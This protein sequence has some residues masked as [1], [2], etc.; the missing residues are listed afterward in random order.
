MGQ[1]GQ[2]SET[3]QRPHYDEKRETVP[4]SI[5]FFRK[6]KEWWMEEVGVKTSIYIT[7]KAAIIIAKFIQEQTGM[8]GSWITYTRIQN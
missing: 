7:I 5:F 4:I 1:E 3:T 2:L 8:C 6:G